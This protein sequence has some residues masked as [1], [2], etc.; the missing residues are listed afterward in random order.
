MFTVTLLSLLKTLTTHTSIML[1]VYLEYHSRY[2]HSH[3]YNHKL[4]SL[5]TV[6]YNHMMRTVVTSKELI[7]LLVR[8]VGILLES[9]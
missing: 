3:F 5:L 4:T 6:V 2:F 9:I 8:K 7:T 1:L